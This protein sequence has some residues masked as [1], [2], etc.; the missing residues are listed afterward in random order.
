MPHPRR[1]EADV[2]RDRRD[3]VF[4]LFVIGMFILMALYGGG[5]TAVIIWGNPVLA[6]RMV[7]GFAAM[8]TGILGF[9]SGYLLGRPKS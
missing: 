1:R 7:A 8:F 6:G 5:M 4:R 3:D 2:E 9:G